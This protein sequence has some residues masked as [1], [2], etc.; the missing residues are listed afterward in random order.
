MSKAKLAKWLNDNIVMITGIPLIIGIHYGWTKLQDIPYLVDQSQKKEMPIVAV[1]NICIL[2]FL[3]Y[4]CF[5]LI[6][7]HINP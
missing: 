1:S 6:L 7:R 4:L 3:L 5:L 2:N